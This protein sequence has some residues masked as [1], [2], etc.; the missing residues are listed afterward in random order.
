MLQTLLDRSG[1]E[2]RSKKKI[3]PLVNPQTNDPFHI[4]NLGKI[5][6]YKKKDH[7]NPGIARVMV[8]VWTSVSKDEE[9]SFIG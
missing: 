4:A 1:K 3:L 2:K 6:R 8:T 9:N 5:L 7:L